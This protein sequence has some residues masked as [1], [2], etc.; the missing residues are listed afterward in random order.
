MNTGEKQSER[1]PAGAR[2][3]SPKLAG[4]AFLAWALHDPLLPGHLIAELVRW[5][6]ALARVRWHSPAL[7]HLL[8]FLRNARG[9]GVGLDWPEF[10][11]RLK[12]LSDNFS[13][14]DQSH[15]RAAD[16]GNSDYGR[17]RDMAISAKSAG[18]AG[19]ACS[20]LK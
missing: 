12:I 19:K 8:D 5:R 9:T 16:S 14:T 20:I 6:S 2:H 1:T 13:A 18:S 10:A 3:S 17:G 15:C 4:F 7:A 11:A